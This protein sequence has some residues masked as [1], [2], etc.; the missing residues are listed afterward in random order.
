MTG[1]LDLFA[2]APA[3]MKNWT[4]TSVAIA[5]SLEPTLIALVEIFDTEGNWGPLVAMFDAHP[6][7]EEA[8]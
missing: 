7:K 1:K 5:S 4:A 6:A 8:A 2:A 3:L